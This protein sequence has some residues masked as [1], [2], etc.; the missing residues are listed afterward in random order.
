[1]P[2]RCANIHK[3]KDNRWEG[4]VKV[5]KYPNGATKYYSVYG[6]TYSEAKEKMD[7]V[8]LNGVA[9][10]K[11]VSS[12]YTF[13]DVVEMWLSYVKIRLKQSTIYRYNFLCLVGTR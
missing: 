10:Q 9:A 4:R 3:R 13:S 7:A 1:M 8:K 12:T 2:K 5:G 11:S 6:K